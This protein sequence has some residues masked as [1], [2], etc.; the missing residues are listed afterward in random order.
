MDECKLTQSVFGNVKNERKMTKR[1]DGKV[2]KIKSGIYEMLFHKIENGANGD[3][4]RLF[5]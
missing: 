2:G 1:I 3:V 4:G 5:Y